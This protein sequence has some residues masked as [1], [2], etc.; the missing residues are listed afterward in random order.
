LHNL[1][2]GRANDVA[3]EEYAH[4]K[5]ELGCLKKQERS[6]LLGRGELGREP[7]N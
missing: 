3:D 5:S 2:A 6:G 7:L 4:R 1:T